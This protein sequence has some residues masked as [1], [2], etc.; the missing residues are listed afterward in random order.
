MIAHKTNETFG[1][2]ISSLHTTQLEI[3]N[4]ILLE[5]SLARHPTTL[6]SL[7]LCF[8]FWR[9]TCTK[10]ASGTFRGTWAGIPVP[11]DPEMLGI[12]RAAF[13]EVFLK[14]WG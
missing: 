7:C 2:Y 3:R 12:C 5:K 1:V 9:V 6:S 14:R 4:V 11:I 8:A 10:R 13:P